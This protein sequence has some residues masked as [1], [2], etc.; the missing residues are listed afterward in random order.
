MAAGGVAHSLQIRADMRLARAL[1]AGKIPASGCKHYFLT[2][3]LR[4][5]NETH[6]GAFGNF[7]RASRVFEGLPMIKEI[8]DVHD[9]RLRTGLPQTGLN[10]HNAARV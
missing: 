7:P 10:L 3:P 5:V 4:K 6:E 9:L 2:D 1:P 8:G